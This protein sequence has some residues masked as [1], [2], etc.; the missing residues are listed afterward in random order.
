MVHFPYL[1]I[2]NKSYIFEIYNRQ[3][4][5]NAQNFCIIFPTNINNLK[6]ENKLMKNNTNMDI[7]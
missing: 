5:Q 1:K 7:H 2:K 3:F 4:R 6:N